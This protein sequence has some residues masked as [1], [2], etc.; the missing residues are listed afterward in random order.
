MSYTQITA[1]IIDHTVRL[2]NIPLLSSGSQGVVQIRCTFDEKW[3][4]YGK[5]AVFY[6]NKK[7]V[8]HVLLVQD[9]ATVPQEVL[10]EEGRFLFGIMG[11]ADN[12]RTTEAVPLNV[13]RGA[14]TTATATPEEPTP[15][16]YQQLVQAYAL[17]EARL[18]EL[19]AM[20][21]TDANVATM[22]ISDD[23]FNGNIR[24]NGT[25]V[26]IYL[27]IDGLSLVGYG[28]HIS[29]EYRLPAVFAPL[30]N[31]VLACNSPDLE[32]TFE[33]TGS[34]SS[35]SG[36]ETYIGA[37][38]RIRNLSSE[39]GQFYGPVADGYCPAAGLSIAEL[40]DLRIRPDGETYPTAG[41]AI[42][43]QFFH[44]T[45]RI[46]YLENI[47]EQLTAAVKALGGSV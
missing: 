39:Y 26:H 10:A 23:Y 30:G 36:G 1:R 9:T 40:A 14:I 18:N 35:T 47:I 44:A 8:Y 20:R 42:R 34:S 17:A 32:V 21:G 16:I 13:V 27:V 2:S 5:T 11:T 41:E 22:N 24:T 46:T 28:E 4:G 15:D 38:V 29:D 37:R 25:G 6:R 7:E 45:T 3:S 19:V 33:L 43:A 31:V 12:T